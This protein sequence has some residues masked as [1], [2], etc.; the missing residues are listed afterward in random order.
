M[1]W[2][3]N[4]AWDDAIADEAGRADGNIIIGGEEHNEFLY[5][6]RQLVCDRNDWEQS[7][8]IRGGL[9]GR[10]A[11]S[12]TD[13]P[14]DDEEARRGRIA[15]SLD[16][17]LLDVPRGQELPAVEEARTT[18]RGAVDLVHVMVASPQRHGGCSPPRAFDGTVPQAT[19][20]G[21]GVKIAVLD[22]GIS[23]LQ[24]PFNMAPDP[25]VETGLP[26]PATGHGTMVAGA[27]AQ[28][29]ADA[30]LVIRS[31]LKLPLGVADEVDVAHA[32]DVL[33]AVDI[34]NASFSGGAV[35]DP[36][37]MLTFQRAVERVPANTVIVAAA[38]NEA[39]STPQFMA[40]FER[41]IGVASVA[42]ADSGDM[43]IA[44][45]SNRGPWVKMCAPGTDVVTLM[46]SGERVTCSGT[47]FAAPQ[48]SAKIAVE[49]KAQ[50]I[51]VVAAATGIV[52]NPARPLIADAG[53][54]L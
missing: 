14:Q 39:R 28:H 45:Y 40:A 37:T 11:R 6:P 25:D 46:R 20:G 26:G 52:G 24:L 1:P 42:R 7:G 9:N 35:D 23:D 47:S 8:E 13:D 33:P 49:A 16:L 21:L 2:V 34:V 15:G 32:L 54:L 19:A 48:V 53:R 17:H 41:V 38:G 30:T 29:A 27:I 44:H 3:H 43:Q 18:R 5:R 12:L 31:V 50:G 4:D 36:E 22:T 51:S 10:G